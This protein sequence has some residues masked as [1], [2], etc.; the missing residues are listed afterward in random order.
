[1]ALKTSMKPQ[2]AK[3]MKVNLMLITA[4]ILKRYILLQPLCV[5]VFFIKKKLL[6]QVLPDGTVVKVNKTV[7]SD[8][9]DDGSSFFFHSTSFH[10]VQSGNSDE[11]ETEV[12]II[13][14]EKQKPKEEV[15]FDEFPVSSTISSI[16][17][18]P[19]LEDYDVIENEYETN[20]IPLDLDESINEVPEENVGIDDGL[21]SDGIA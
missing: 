11:E 5:K 15:E 6:F 7:I 12:E 17:E 21:K 14:E 9:S 4:L 10:N 16:S 3:K 18:I 19:I 13:P 2:S 20:E 8:T 1:M